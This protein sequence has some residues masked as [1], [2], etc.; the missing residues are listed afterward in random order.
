MLFVSE[1]IDLHCIYSK[2]TLILT[3]FLGG[4][5]LLDAAGNDFATAARSTGTQYGVIINTV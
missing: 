2:Q 5:S 3:L 1:A 4:I